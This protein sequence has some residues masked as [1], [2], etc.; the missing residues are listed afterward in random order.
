MIPQFLPV[1]PGWKVLFE[2]QNRAK[3]WLPLL[4]WLHGPNS[5][6]QPCVW[7]SGVTTAD[8]VAAELGLPEWSVVEQDYD[9]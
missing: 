8:K 7:W 2:G 5:G 4:G 6:I 9:A 3:V 1:P